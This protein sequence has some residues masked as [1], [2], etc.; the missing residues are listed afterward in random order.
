MLA[1]AVVASLVILVVM[2]FRIDQLRDG[3]SAESVQRRQVEAE[4]ARAQERITSLNS[5]LQIL[6]QN[7]I[8]GVDQLVYNRQIEL[9]DQYVQSITFVESGLGNE[10]TVE[11]STV[12]QNVRTGPILPKVTIVLFDEAGMQTG[13]AQLDRSHTITP[14]DIPEMQPGETRTYSTRIEL[15]REQPSKYFVVE[16]L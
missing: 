13:M 12:L 5:D 8:P 16:V 6:L 9:N 7:R 15:N 10:K 14:V 4:L 3:R 2:Y 1:S 11:F